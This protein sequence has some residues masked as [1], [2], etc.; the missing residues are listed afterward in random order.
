M[1]VI[2]LAGGLG[3]RLGSVSELMPKPMVNVGEKPMLWHVMKIYSHYGFNEFV[4]CLGYKGKVVKDYFY[5]F[6]VNNSDLTVNLPSG[7]IDYHNS[8]NEDWKVTLVDTGL[9]TLKGGRIKRVEQYL[10]SD[11]CMLTYGDG[12][13]DIDL[14]ALLEFH[15]SHKKILTITGVRP[16]SMF[17]EVI[18]KDGKVISF[19][20]KPQTSKGLINGGFMVFNK[21]ML[22]YLTVNEDCDFEFGPMEK[23]A[24]MGQVMTYKHNGF[25]ECADTIRDIE[26]LNKHWESGTAPWKKWS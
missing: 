25:W 8:S 14:N 1:K 19:E 3:T 11:I 4:I 7:D 15:H 12:V 16:P 17:G 18:E 20:E 9:D 2:I 21:K 26:N 5:N 10:D 6:N 24:G 13:A 22:D 23:L